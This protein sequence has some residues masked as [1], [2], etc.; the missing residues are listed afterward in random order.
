MSSWDV[1]DL[2]NPSR[3]KPATGTFDGGKMLTAKKS[4]MP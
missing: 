2:K 3:Q 1:E 4:Y